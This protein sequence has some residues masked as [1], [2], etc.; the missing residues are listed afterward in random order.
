MTATILASTTA[1]GAAELQ[2]AGPRRDFIELARVTGARIV[3][4]SAPRGARGWRTRLLG[5]HVAQAW[6]ASATVDR[7]SAVF[8]DG[9]HNGLPLLLFLA[10]RRRRALRVVMLGHLMS[11]GWKRL[12]ARALT[13]MGQPGEIWLHSTCQQEALDG[14]VGPRWR[15][16]LVPYQVD[17][18]FWVNSGRPPGSRFHIVAVGSEHRDYRTLVEAVTGLDVD[19]TIAA[20]SHWARS[21]A[22]LAD[23]LPANVRLVT[24]TLGFR[25]LR[26]LYQQAHCVVVPLEEVENQSGV[27]TILEAMSMALPV[28]VSATR[29]QR[30]CVTGPLM[31][32]QGIDAEVTADRGPVNFGH[33]RSEPCGMYVPPGDALALRAAIRHLSGNADECLRLG[34]AGRLTAVS[35]FGFEAYITRLA[36]ALT[37]DRALV[38]GAPL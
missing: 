15:T 17:T 30:E 6:R 18:A 9:E 32:A 19:L 5:P 21:A 11:S 14:L 37:P 24:S 20:G 26:D 34:E 22:S 29:G 33:A 31:T 25:D 13:R 38:S 3:F 28:V 8:A 7:D 12:L 35:A 27:T 4:A 10:L 36:S 2:E 1:A 23:E 16:A